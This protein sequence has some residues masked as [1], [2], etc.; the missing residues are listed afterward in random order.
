M[1]DFA[2]GGTAI[3]GGFAVGE[4]VVAGCHLVIGCGGVGLGLE[5]WFAASR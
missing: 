3:V 2:S 5:Q 1:S 4:V